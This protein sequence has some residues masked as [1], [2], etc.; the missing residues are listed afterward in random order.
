MKKVYLFSLSI[1][2]MLLAANRAYAQDFKVQG[3]VTDADGGTLIG[4]TV[5]IAGTTKGVVTD[6]KGHYE[7][8]V[9]SGSDELIFSYIGCVSQTVKV[10]TRRTINVSLKTDLFVME[11]V[12]VTGYQT[13]SKERATG[14]FSKLN[15]D[16]WNNKRIVGVSDILEGKIAGYSNGIIRGTTSFYAGNQPLYVVDG[17]PVE[18]SRY[19]STGTL[20]D[21]LPSLNMDDVESVTVLKD[22]AAT[23]IYGARAANGVVVIITKKAKANQT[24]ISFSSTFT[25]TPYDYYTGN[26]A[27]SKT[28]IDIER[29]L[30]SA[31][32]IFQ[33]PSV[34]QDYLNRATYNSQGIKALLNYYAGNSTEAEMNS[35]LTALEGNGHAYVKDIS[36]YGKRNPFSQQYNFSASHGTGKNSTNVSFTYIN[37]LPEDK[38]SNN[39]N[40]GGNITTSFNFTKWLALDF[41]TYFNYKTGTAQT[42]NLSSPTYPYSIYDRLVNP[43]GSHYTVLAADRLAQASNNTINTYG[44]YSMDVTPLD[45]IA[46]NRAKTRDFSNRSYVRL[47]IKLADFLQYSGSF[48]YEY[49]NYD[50]VRLN[51]KESYTVRSL[52]NSYSSGTIGS[53][54]YNIP[55]GDTYIHNISVSNSYNVR[56]QM[57]FDKTF[58]GVHNVTA[59]AGFEARHMKITHEGVTKYNYDPQMLTHSAINHESYVG[60]Y[61]YGLLGSGYMSADAV[62][63]LVNRYVSLYGNAA[64]NYDNRYTAT[65]SLRWDRSNLWGK[66]SQ[67]QDKPTWSVG[68]AWNVS[69]E[70]FFKVDWVNRLKV[71]A[72]YGIGGNISKD[73]SPYLVASYTN[74]TNVG[75]LQGNI[76]KQPNPLLSW[77]KTTTINIGTDFALLGNRLMGSIDY[78][79]KNGTNLLSNTMGNP[80][81]GFG[82]STM[83]INNGEVRNHG[84][85][86]VLSGQIIRK[87]DYGWNASVVFAHNKNKVV[88][89]TTKAPAAYLQVD[90]P[91]EYP[92]VGDP[93]N[94]IYGFKWAG[95][96]D[97]GV[98]QIYN[99]AGEKTSFRPSDLESIV[100]VGTKVPVY[101]GSFTTDFRYKD[102]T[103]SFMFLYEGGHKVRNTRLPWLSTSYSSAA[104]GYIPYTNGLI[105]SGITDRWKQAGDE[106]HT[107]IPRLMLSIADYRLFD[108]TIYTNADIN[109]LNA[110]NIRLRNASLSYNIPRDIARK[111]YM[112]NAR[113]IFNIENPFM[114]AHS[115]EAKYLLGGYNKPSYVLGLNFNF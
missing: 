6:E 71:R 69:N 16:E 57:N 52:T 86:V 18:S 96:T 32:P 99:S 76:S 94:A 64:Y 97:G 44:L 105:S 75:G 59:L 58:A 38:Y 103:L 2:I 15:S 17:F 90:Y 104:G 10:G 108:E 29:E 55:Y 109:V 56:Q 93:Y 47:N 67:Y 78:Y 85:E 23:S 83:Q 42:F 7:V 98:P 95:L 5:A 107:N 62:K 91:N 115:K 24:N 68:G 92:R 26:V 53:V 106:N 79:R 9:S 46:M 61:F 40:L 13:I 21:I 3:V 28:I 27:D 87:K 12:V 51:N 113:A 114:I 11:E 111:L 25:F 73:S 66:S 65:G 102:F 33:T 54:V 101:N 74:N 72:S 20:T 84:I 112:Q 45:E 80:T 39:E 70:S 14:S 63:E 77:E 35:K 100:Y 4:V 37:D 60:K 30:I 43:D 36:K 41:G 8:S 50:Y 89:A 31:N 34:A 110:G 1:L 81:E 88:S 48:Q 82:Y 49:A 22:A 19:S